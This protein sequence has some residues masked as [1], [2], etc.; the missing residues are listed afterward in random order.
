MNKIETIRLNIENAQKRKFTDSQIQSLCEHF[1]NQIDEE[2]LDSFTSTLMSNYSKLSRI[3]EGEH[4]EPELSFDNLDTFVYP[5]N[6]NDSSSYLATLTEL[7]NAAGICDNYTP[8]HV[9]RISAYCRITAEKLVPLNNNVL[10][11]DFPNV[12]ATASGFHDIGK[13]AISKNILSKTEKLSFGEAEIMKTHVVLGYNILTSALEIHPRC[14]FLKMGCEIA[15]HHHEK[16]D[17]SGYASGLKGQQIP[18]AARIVALAHEYDDLRSKDA[19]SH[20]EAIEIVMADKG[21]HFD[22]ILVDIFQEHNGAY[23]SIFN[24]TP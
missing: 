15:L 20:E 6:N 17:G 2:H 8:S 16:W 13:I 18:L 12:I 9:K 1:A 14:R 11:E 19:C 23:C 7:A 24:N 5:T 3:F 21:I 10:G 22:P 4:P